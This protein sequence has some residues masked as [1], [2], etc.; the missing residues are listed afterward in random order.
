MKRTTSMKLTALALALTA[1]GTV[2]AQTSVTLYGLISAGV[3]YSNSQRTANGQAHSAVQFASGPLQTPRWGLRG[4]EDLGGGLSAIFTLESGYSIGTGAMSQGGREFGRQAF[5]GLSSVNY[6]TVTFGRQYDEAVTLCVYSSSCQFAG[7][8]PHVGDN[9]NVF[10]TF[11]INNSVQYKSPSIK[12]LQFEG[13]YGF[14]NAPGGFSDNNAYSA[15]IQYAMGAFSVGAMFVQLNSPNDAANQGGA[16]AGDYGFTSPF[17]TNPVSGSGV[18][19]Q[20]IAG[21]GGGYKWGTWNVSAIYTNTRFDYRDTSHLTLSNAE[22][23]VYDYVRPDIMVGLAYIFTTGQ[24][25]P[26]D[27]QP[28]YHQ[29]NAGLDYILSKRTDLFVHATYQKAAGDAQYAQIYT[30]SPSGTKNQ[31]AATLGMRHKW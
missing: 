26:Q 19:S 29:V 3:V 17:I 14:S 30:L 15:G 27:S 10:D 8:G 7:I 4:S 23:S 22:L 12:G 28:T 31:F 13:L 2:Q 16:V 9:D 5:V 24:Y 1:A 6:G 25:A 18:R 20:R 21:V 11:R